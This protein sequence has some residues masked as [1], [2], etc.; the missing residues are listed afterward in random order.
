M[1]EGKVYNFSC[2]RVRKTNKYKPVSS[3]VMI[4][5][6]QWTTVEEVV[7]VLSGF[8]AFTYSLISI[9]E[10]PSCKDYMEY[11]RGDKLY[12]DALSVLPLSQTHPLFLTPFRCHWDSHYG[13]KCHSITGKG[14][15]E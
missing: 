11:F 9:E 5:L 14:A 1:K 13:L 3:D 4:S 2:F 7:E 6:S 15:T 8:P 10:I 12:F